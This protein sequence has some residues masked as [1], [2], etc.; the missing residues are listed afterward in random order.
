MSDNNEDINHEVLPLLSVELIKQQ[1]IDTTGK[2]HLT[3]GD[4]YWGEQFYVPS[5]KEVQDRLSLKGIFFLGIV[6]DANSEVDRKKSLPII[7]ETTSKQYSQTIGWVHS[8]FLRVDIYTSIVL[9]CKHVFKKL[10][11]KWEPAFWATDRAIVAVWEENYATQIYG[12]DW[13]IYDIFNKTFIPT[14][15]GHVLDHKYISNEFVHQLKDA[16]MNHEKYREIYD[17]VLMCQACFK[18]SMDG[19]NK[20]YATTDNPKTPEPF[21]QLATEIL[22]KISKAQLDV[23]KPELDSLVQSFIEYMS[24]LSERDRDKLLDSSVSM[25]QL[26]RYCTILYPAKKGEE[27]EVSDDFLDID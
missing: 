12:L 20:N 16:G 5:Y 22:F 24:N 11:P 2:D 14:I 17:S 25:V 1:L 19:V 7:L 6:D 4:K 9:A 18:I 3:P 8:I 27:I 21:I 10:Y 13:G 23:N 15:K 26:W